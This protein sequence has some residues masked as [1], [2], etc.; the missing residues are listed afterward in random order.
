MNFAAYISV[1]KMLKPAILLLVPLLLFQTHTST[2]AD[3]I[4]EEP[5]YFVDIWVENSDES[6]SNAYSVAQGAEVHIGCK[7]NEN[8]NDTHYPKA[9][10]LDVGI[11][12]EDAAKFKEVSHEQFLHIHVELFFF[13]QF[14]VFSD[15]ALVS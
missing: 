7:V 1:S 15:M 14:V 11:N 3:Y 9:A 6:A 5:A 10:V 2:L 13:G 4:T 12:G 8:W